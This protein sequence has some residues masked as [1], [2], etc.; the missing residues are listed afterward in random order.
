MENVILGK[1]RNIIFM[2]ALYSAGSLI[3]ILPLFIFKNIFFDNIRDLLYFKFNTGL[4][5]V[6]TASLIILGG[7]DRVAR[8]FQK[9][10]DDNI[11]E[12]FRVFYSGCAEWNVLR[13]VLIALLCIIGS[14][15][16]ELLFRGYLLHLGLLIPI[17]QAVPISMML[18]SLIFAFFH[19][20]QGK[21]VFITS[22][23]I[24]LVFC[25]WTIQE[26][27]IIIP[28][29]VHAA[30][31]FIEIVIILPAQMKHNKNT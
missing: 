21:F 11:S 3:L 19:Y 18:V 27:S 1:F 31:N 8:I 15:F 26:S 17:G 30:F 6:I 10:S 13:A 20:N 16:E 9:E 25:I 28:I 29:I 24:S 2:T 5:F 22:F 4:F 14:F 12:L 23:I 7:T